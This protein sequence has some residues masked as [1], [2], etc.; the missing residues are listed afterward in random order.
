MTSMLLGKSKYLADAMVGHDNNLNLIRIIAASLV[1]FSHTFTVVTGDSKREPLRLDYGVT[2]G[3]ISVD[4]FLIIS[5]LLVTI[6]LIRGND[7]VKFA[8]S[9]FLRIW[10]GLTISFLITVLFYHSFQL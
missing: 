7:A 6:S 3:S 1:L 8:K 10:P 5:G 2:L 9:R 4:V